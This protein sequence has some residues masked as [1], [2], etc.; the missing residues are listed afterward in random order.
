MTNKTD[1]YYD[2]FITNNPYLTGLP[3]E[4]QFGEHFLNI[5]LAPQVT[6]EMLLGKGFVLGKDADDDADFYINEDGEPQMTSQ[7]I[8][9]NG[10]RGTEGEEGCLP[11]EWEDEVPE[12]IGLPDDWHQGV[13]LD[14]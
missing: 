11:F 13:T 8:P 9:V 3:E 5:A 14:G 2:K 4:E 7:L 10:D 6:K 12:L 1:V